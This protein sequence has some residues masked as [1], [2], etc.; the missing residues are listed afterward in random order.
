MAIAASTLAMLGSG[1]GPT[2]LDGAPEDLEHG[3]RHGDGDTDCA[4]KVCS[5]GGGLVVKDP[6]NV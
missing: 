1:L 4:G 6:P 5:W 3:A 2:T